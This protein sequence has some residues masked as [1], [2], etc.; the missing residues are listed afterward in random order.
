MLPTASYLIYCY[1]HYYSKK[2]I[3]AKRVETILV[4][5]IVAPS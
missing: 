2:N 3:A 5:T 4:E 1:V